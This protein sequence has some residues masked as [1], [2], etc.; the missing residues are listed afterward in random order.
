MEHVG[1][2]DIRRSCIDSHKQAP[3]DMTLTLDQVDVEPDCIRSSRT[4]TSPAFASPIRGQDLWTIRDGK[5]D[6]LETTFVDA[7]R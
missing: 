6:R 5:I 4:C 3:P 2:D 7:P 1:K